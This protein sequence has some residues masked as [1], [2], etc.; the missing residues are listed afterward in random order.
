MAG[1]LRIGTRT[2]LAFSMASSFILCVFAVALYA[3]YS[4][5]LRTET[6]NLVRLEYENIAAEIASTP[7]TSEEIKLQ[8]K[9]LD[10]VDRA[11]N[12]GLL[13]FA[14]DSSNGHAILSPSLLGD[15]I[16][17]GESGFFRSSVENQEYLFYGNV[18]GPVE[19]IVGAN[20]DVHIASKL[21]SLARILVLLVLSGTLGSFFLSASLSARALFPLRKLA[22][23]VDNLDP[24]AS[25]PTSSIASEY[26][27][28]EIGYL[29]SAFDRFAHRIREFI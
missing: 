24:D 3:A 12:Q 14:Y 23:D 22:A 25:V 2:A 11:T 17:A 20:E 9:T 10:R 15:S 18:V 26:P 13:V 5:T 1:T 27:D 16:P 4:Q 8:E 28:D 29:A 6:E 21:S 7:K 19:L